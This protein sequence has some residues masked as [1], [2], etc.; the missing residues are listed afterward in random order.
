MRRIE[1]A[2]HCGAFSPAW[3][4][5][6]GPVRRDRWTHKVY[7]KLDAWSYVADGVQFSLVVRL[8]AKPCPAPALSQDI[9]FMAWLDGTPLAAADGKPKE[10]RDPIAAMVAVED[11]IAERTMD[12]EFCAY[13]A[14]NAT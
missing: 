5:Q 6:K 8:P 3:E 11:E 9:G 2:Q 12:A 14:A 4:D 7:R 10:F 13:L 1:H